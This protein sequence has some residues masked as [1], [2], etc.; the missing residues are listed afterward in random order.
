MASKYGDYSTAPGGGDAE[1]WA[2][3]WYALFTYCLCVHLLM[4]RTDAARF[5]CGGHRGRL[6]RITII[7]H[8]PTVSW[9]F[10]QPDNSLASR[11]R[12]EWSGLHVFCFLE[13]K[14]FHH[15]R[16]HL[17]RLEGGSFIF[18]FPFYILFI[19]SFTKSTAKSTEEFNSYVRT[20]LFWT[21]E[22]RAAVCS[23]L[24]Y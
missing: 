12:Y 11:G 3:H 9:N 23:F 16:L 24:Y 13:N 19:A 21:P 14:F 20:K 22:D 10:K 7:W 1:C 18:L 17:C 8:Y 4:W 15:W 5:F 6:A 2:L